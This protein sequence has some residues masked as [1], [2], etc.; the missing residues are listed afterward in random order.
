MNCFRQRW[1]IVGNDLEF[2]PMTLTFK[3]NYNNYYDRSGKVNMKDN[4]KEL[5]PLIKNIYKI[6]MT[7]AMKGCYLYFVDKNLEQYMKERLAP[8]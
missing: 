4:P 6:L 8:M 7:R 1:Y 3:S 2:D 5:N